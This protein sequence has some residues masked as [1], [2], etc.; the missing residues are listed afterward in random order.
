MQKNMILLFDKIWYFLYNSSLK[1]NFEGCND[2]A[3]KQYKKFEGMLIEERKRILA[4]QKHGAEISGEETNVHD[5]GDIAAE[6]ADKLVGDTARQS[7]EQILKSIDRALEH[8]NKGTYGKCVCCKGG[9]S[10]ARLEIL[11]TAEKCIKCAQ[12]R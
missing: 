9:I 5:V 2:M 10:I 12:K 7:D 6:F 8:I 3:T 4:R 11:P 1:K